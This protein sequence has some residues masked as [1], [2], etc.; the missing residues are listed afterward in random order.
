ME[1]KLNQIE[2]NWIEQNIIFFGFS[3]VI[4]FIEI[5]LKLNLLKFDQIEVN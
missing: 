2:L 1:L 4:V 5:S 3:R